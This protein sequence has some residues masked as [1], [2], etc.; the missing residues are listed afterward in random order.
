MELKNQINAVESELR[1]YDNAKEYIANELHDEVANSLA[2][3]KMY[4]NILCHDFPQN[5]Y[6]LKT[7]N[8]IDMVTKKVRNLSHSLFMKD[9]DDNSISDYLRMY[10]DDFNLAGMKE[11]IDL[12]VENEVYLSHLSN[13]IKRDIYLIFQ[14]CIINIIKHA[15]AQ[16]IRVNLEMTLNGL[17]TLQIIDDGEG[18]KNNR[19]F[20]HG[21]GITNIK[22]RVEKYTGFLS[23]EKNEPQGTIIKVQFSIS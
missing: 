19:L 15:K 21:T 23:I 18:M 6:I 3:I 9:I 13:G 10:C 4:L 5:A 16:L 12:V 14:E 7:Q 17:I 1:G 8:T 2:T 11:R 20:F 22:K